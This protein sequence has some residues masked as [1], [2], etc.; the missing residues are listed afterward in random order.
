[1]SVPPDEVGWALLFFHFLVPVIL[2]HITVGA[3]W[4]LYYIGL[5]VAVECSHLVQNTLAII[6]KVALL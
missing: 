1:M 5:V 6:L 4:F 3:V 2:Y